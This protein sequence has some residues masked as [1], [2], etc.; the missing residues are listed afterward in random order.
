MTLEKQFVIQNKNVLPKNIRL[1]VGWLDMLKVFNKTFNYI[2]WIQ[3]SK[4]KEVF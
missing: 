1:E 3:E 4:T 2:R